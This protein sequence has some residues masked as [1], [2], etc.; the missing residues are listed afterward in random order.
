MNLFFLPSFRSFELIN[1]IHQNISEHI[2]TDIQTHLYFNTRVYI[3][4]AHREGNLI[5]SWFKLQTVGV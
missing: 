2:P 3:P 5:S 1:V 4:T